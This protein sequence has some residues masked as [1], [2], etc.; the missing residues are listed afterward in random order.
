MQPVVSEYRQA[1]SI[2]C[3]ACGTPLKMYGRA[4]LVGAHNT[5]H[6]NAMPAM[7]RIAVQCFAMPCMARIAPHGPTWPRNVSHC[8]TMP[9]IACIASNV[10]QWASMIFD[11][12]TH[13]R[14]PDDRCRAMVGD[15]RDAPHCPIAMQY[16]HQCQAMHP[17]P[18]MVGD[19]HY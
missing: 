10:L 18:I 14:C 19:R 16:T 9:C 4:P 12:G 15:A 3:C 13:K 8:R 2:R 7:F 6:C 17:W 1:G 5:P 11:A